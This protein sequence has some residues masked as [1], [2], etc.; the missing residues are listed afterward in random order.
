MDK[1][2]AHL[3]IDGR[4]QGVFY[5]GFTRELAENLGLKGWVSNLSDGRVEAV[6]EGD[7]DVIE[8]AIRECYVGPPGSRVTNID[9]QWET[10]TG[11][12]KDFSVRHTH[13]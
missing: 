7:R 4:V 9:I 13:W 1:A 5:R 12:E 8:S 3:H 2:K 10:Y 6:F 11:E